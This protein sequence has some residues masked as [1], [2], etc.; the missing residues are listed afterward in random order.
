MKC[1]FKYQNEIIPNCSLSFG[2]YFYKI[3][4]SKL[5]EISRNLGGKEENV[6]AILGLS[7]LCTVKVL[8][9]GK[10]PFSTPSSFHSSVEKFLFS[11]EVIQE[12]EI[13]HISHQSGQ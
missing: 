2:L 5:S 1:V 8:V 13:E 7:A 6:C 12:G 9:C 11:L 3:V 10:V 4:Y